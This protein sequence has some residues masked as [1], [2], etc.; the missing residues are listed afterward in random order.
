MQ[1]SIPPI[2][3]DDAF[4]DVE[5]WDEEQA[6]YWTDALNQRAAAPDQVALR[7]HLLKHSGMKSG[8]TVLELGCG[9][10]RLL[11]DLARATGASGRAFGLE[12]QPS[13]AKEAERFIL[14]QELAAMT[15]VLSGRAEEIPLPDASVDLC[16]AQT[17]LIHIPTG[18]LARVFSEVK[19]VLKPGGRFISVDQDGDTWTIDHPQRAVT[20]RVVQFNSD[21][22][23]ADGWTGRYLRRLFRQ[24]GFEEV[25]NQVWTQSE[26]E[27]GS[28]LYAMACRIAQSAAEHG[29]LSPDECKEWLHELDAQSQEGN[30]FSSIGYFCCQGRKSTMDRALG[31]QNQGGE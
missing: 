18:L 2:G 1:D 30:F 12:P 31:D 10:G 5:I 14:E 24:S 20:R 19:R 27:R 11:S 8:D 23:Y 25:P 3:S 21:Y 28:Y 9:T 4:R 17:V 15:R 13:F 22:R 16:V 29:A 6:R 7:V 26:T